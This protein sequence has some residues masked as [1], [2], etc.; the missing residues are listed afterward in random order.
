MGRLKEAKETAESANRAKSDFLANM[1]HEIRTPMNAIVGMSELLIDT[2]L[3]PAQREYATMVQESADSLLV[4]INDILD[5]SKI[6]AGRFQLDPAPFD[7]QESVGDTLK[8][9]AERAH[10]R[11]LE[12]AY[13]IDLDIPER[14][15]GDRN[16]LRQVIVNLVGNAIKFTEEGEVVL[17]A[18][19]EERTDQDLLIH[20][21]VKDTGVGISPEKQERIFQAF[22]QADESTTR[23]YGGTGLGL[24]IAS[25]LVEMMNTSRNRNG[26]RI[27]LVV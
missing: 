2:K 1:S 6:E 10:G 16:R 24:A 5:F 11:G 19:C 13:H 27:C 23:H 3:T 7:L 22:E 20:F 17:D 15:V 12:L 26:P 8:A 18:E 9:L 4:L 14:L 25:R 21:T